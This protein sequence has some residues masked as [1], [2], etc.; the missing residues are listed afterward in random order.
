MHKQINISKQVICMSLHR[1]VT[2]VV[3][4]HNSGNSHFGTLVRV[5]QMKTRDKANW[6]YRVHICAFATDIFD[7]NV[8]SDKLHDE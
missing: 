7:I 2:L 4:L 3:G 6:E 5:G 1:S 8:C